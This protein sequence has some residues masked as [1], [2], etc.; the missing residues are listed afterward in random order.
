MMDIKTLLPKIGYASNSYLISS[1]NQY[2][3]ID[4]SIP[5]EE[6][7]ET[8]YIPAG[9]LKYILVTHAHFDH[10]LEI[11]SW[12]NATG[13]T[14]IVSESDRAALSDSYRNC[15]SLF[16]NEDKGYFGEA[17]SVN[18]NDML[19]LGDEFIEII[20]LPGHTPGCIAFKIGD[21]MFVG[22][23]VFAFG[24]GRYDLPGG[25]FDSLK[26]S[27]KK[28]MSYSDEVRVYSGHG[29][30]STIGSIKKNFGF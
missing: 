19:M 16:L 21:D 6:I 30:S 9:A 2:A 1:A 17:R 18:E 20:S 10:I 26:S 11:D 23:T 8:A 27:I 24:Y 4:P 22:D 15:Y 29:E 7:C 13:A 12:V 28:L 25:D 14:V 5:Y 3:V